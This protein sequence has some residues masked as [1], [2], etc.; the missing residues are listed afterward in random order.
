MAGVAKPGVVWS[1]RWDFGDGKADRLKYFVVLNDCDDATQ[2]IVAA[3]T[4]SQGVKRY[5]NGVDSGRQCGDDDP[6]FRLEAGKLTLFN[7]ASWVQFDNLL[8]RNGRPLTLAELHAAEASGSARM[9]LAI[10]EE[11][12][13]S[14]LRCAS[15]SL[16]IEGV[17]LKQIE[18]AY[19]RLDKQRRAA[20]EAAKA[21]VSSKKVAPSVWSS[22]TIRERCERD[23]ISVTSFYAALEIKEMSIDMRLAGNSRAKTIEDIEAAFEL[24]CESIAPSAKKRD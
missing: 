11:L 18:K 17:W 6:W 24:L 12:L 21:S 23:G 1:I 7:D 10:P 8:I 15:H 2:P 13:M 3:F 14:L 16:D 4:T 9:L 5:G 20:S 22:R 19:A